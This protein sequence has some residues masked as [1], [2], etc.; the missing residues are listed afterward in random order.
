MHSHNIQIC[1]GCLAGDLH[2]VVTRLDEHNSTLDA[3]DHTRWVATTLREILELIE[4]A[5]SFLSGTSFRT[6]AEAGL[7]EA[8][9]QRHPLFSGTTSLF[10]PA[11]H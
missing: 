11:A 4:D 1:A 2:L 5:T 10:R 9:E 8:P 7:G 6:E 3:T